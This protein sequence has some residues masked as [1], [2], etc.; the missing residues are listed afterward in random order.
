MKFTIRKKIESNN[1]LLRMHWAV[2]TREK[3]DWMNEVMVAMPVGSRGQHREEKKDVEI[4]SHRSR[5]LDKD[6]LYGGAKQL[7]DALT[8]FGLIKDDSPKYCNLTVSQEL[9]NNEKTVITIRKAKE[10]DKES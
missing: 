5:R 4:V 1:K 10:L 9:S 8:Y 7:I 3:E 6:N 2:R